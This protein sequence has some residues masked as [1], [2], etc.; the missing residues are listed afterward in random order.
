MRGVIE[1]IPNGEYAHDDFID[2]DGNDARAH[3]IAVRV[4]I[5]GS[6]VT[7]DFTGSS[8]QAAGPTNSVYGMTWAS[9][10]NALLQMSPPDMPFNSGCFRPVKLIAPRHTLVSPQPPAAVFAGTVETSLRTIDAIVGALIKAMPDDLVAATYGTAFCFGGGGFDPSR[11]SD[12]AFFFVYE[13][14]W[15]GSSSR[16]GWTCVPNQTSNFKDTPVEIMEHLYPF[17]WTRSAAP[18]PAGAGRFRGSV[19][20]SARTPFSAAS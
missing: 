19:G 2:D 8:A 16:D 7:V 20:R 15:G 5:E 12:Y 1:R 17:R 4:A 6:D 18:R 14:G 10:F 9:T 3:R 11:G 13:G